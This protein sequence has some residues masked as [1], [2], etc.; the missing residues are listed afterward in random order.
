MHCRINHLPGTVGN[1]YDN[2]RGEIAQMERY[3]VNMI[4]SALDKGVPLDELKLPHLKLDAFEALLEEFVM[5]MNWRTSHRL[6]GFDEVY[7]FEMSEGNFI[8][9]DDPR[10]AELIPVGAQAHRR[11]EAPMERAARLMQGHRMLPV[12]ASQLY[13]LGLDK[14][15][16]TVRAEKVTI[17][18]YLSG[19]DNLIF[20]DRETAPMLAE[21][22]GQENALVGFMAHDGS[23]M[24]LF[25]NDADMNY[26][27]SP[28][29][30]GR[31]DMNDEKAILRRSGEVHRSRQVVRD[32]VAE[33]IAPRDR[34]YADMRAHNADRL[35]R[36]ETEKAAD[37][38]LQM[39]KAE[40]RVEKRDA[41][42]V[43]PQ[44]FNADDLLN[45]EPT[46]R[47]DAFSGLNAD[48]LL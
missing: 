14:R 11:M 41:A 40:T 34:Q 26:V 44:H 15:V 16:I 33:L 17:Q 6:Q 42:K 37:V 5:R 20:R 25:T 29:R 2:T 48:D 38:A 47:E 1:R 43:S 10:A 45:D 18:S 22:N 13:P 12:H 4:K 8:R 46:A 28:R 7:E 31:A 23:C 3:S 32:A 39:A 21:W 36:A 19:K 35:E 27:C 9:H 30:L 24:H